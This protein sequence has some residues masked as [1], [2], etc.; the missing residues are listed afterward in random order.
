LDAEEWEMFGIH[1]ERGFE[2]LPDVAVYHTAA[3]G[4]S[5]I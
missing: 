3:D 5:A 4:Q 1:A 2:S